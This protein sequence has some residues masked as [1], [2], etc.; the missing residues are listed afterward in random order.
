MFPKFP[1]FTASV[2]DKGSQLF[3]L[4]LVAS[5]PLL[6]GEHQE[7]GDGASNEGTWRPL[8]VGFLRGL[9]LALCES[10]ATFK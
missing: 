8:R 2:F 10:A 6:T 7:E 9:F 4:L 3:D 1:V 5:V